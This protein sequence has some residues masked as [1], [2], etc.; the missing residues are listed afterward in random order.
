MNG[1]MAAA[2]GALG[3]VRS[4]QMIIRCGWYDRL[5]KKSKALRILVV[6]GFCLFCTG[7]TI[8]YDTYPAEN[9][10]RLQSYICPDMAHAKYCYTD[11]SNG[12]RNGVL[13]PDTSLTCL[14]IDPWH[15]GRCDAWCRTNEQ[16]VGGE[17]VARE[18]LRPDFYIS[19]SAGCSPLLVTFYD[20]TPK[21][22]SGPPRSWKWSF[23]YP[24]TGTDGN[25]DPLELIQYK[26]YPAPKHLYGP[27]THTIR[28]TVEN[29]D[30]ISYRERTI[31]VA[32]VDKCMACSFLASPL[33]GCAPLEVTFIDMS[34]VG[35]TEAG[36]P[37]T[38]WEWS[39]GD[40][41]L[42][43]N[44]RFP[45]HTYTKAGTYKP[46]LQIFNDHGTTNMCQLWEINVKPCPRELSE[47]GFEKGEEVVQRGG[48]LRPGLPEMPGM[49]ADN[50]GE[51]GIFAAILRLPGRVLEAIIGTSMGGGEK[52]AD[53]A[54]GISGSV[55]CQSTG[56]TDCSGTCKNLL[57]DFWNCGACGISCGLGEVCSNGICV[58]EISVKGNA[59]LAL[60]GHCQA[61]G[62][63]A[64]GSG[65][66]DL[67]SDAQNCG[68]CGNACPSQAKCLNG[69]CVETTTQ[70]VYYPNPN[71]Q[72]YCASQGRMSCSG[73]CVNLLT[74]AS[75]C[76]SCGNACRSP[77][78]CR[79]GICVAP[80]A[81]PAVPVA[82]TT[83]PPL[84]CGKM[85]LS[86]CRGICVDLK[87]DSLNCGS[88]SNRCQ[89]PSSCRNGICIA[90]TAE[91]PKPTVTVTKAV[92][93]CGIL[94]KTNCGGTCVDLQ[95]DW[96]NCGSCG[97]ACPTGNTCEA[98]RCCTKLINPLSHTT[99]K[100]CEQ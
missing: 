64:C 76:G 49:I 16:C 78:S 1:I 23:D 47:S 11:I 66:A 34:A 13:G 46:I 65:C 77:A 52:P 70:Q 60:P 90:L 73:S 41:S 98:G 31:E 35:H 96:N 19:P 36:Y 79:N 51:E 29:A 28:L 48:V 9:P 6:L 32:P 2:W 33:E 58:P 89:P 75:N 15:C 83:S 40:S 21:S 27:G 99:T 97:R 86:S 95:T 88:C 37:I 10:A 68:S 74:D 72:D 71:V 14:D 92:V 5:G 50:P 80:V 57:S 69:I 17:C 24:R 7:I 63:T 59:A 26:N 45:K 94:G 22:P 100:V 20:Q 3:N 87:T 8:A 67:S 38:M 18:K 85:G 25:G 43:S 61:Q 84:D 81:T 12:V 39:F 82:S 91:Q 54:S 53:T 55:A 44:E 42:D 30:G 62:K 56:L 4:L 93:N